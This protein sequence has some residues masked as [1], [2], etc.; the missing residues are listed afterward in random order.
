MKTGKFKQPIKSYIPL[1]DENKN[2]YI[3]LADVMKFLNI[4]HTKLY[5]MVSV[6]LMPKSIRLGKYCYWRVDKLKES[7]NRLQNEAT[8][9][10]TKGEV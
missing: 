5:Q 6:G 7:L 9:K 3:R 1:P 2:N 10:P 8:N 4:G